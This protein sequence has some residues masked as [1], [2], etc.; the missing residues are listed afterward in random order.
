MTKLL[1]QAAKFVSRGVSVEALRGLSVATAQETVAKLDAGMEDPAYVGAG[2]VNAVGPSRAVM[3]NEFVTPAQIRQVGD[4]HGAAH[5]KMANGVRRMSFGTP[6]ACRN[7]QAET[8]AMM[9]NCGYVP[10]THPMAPGEMQ[11]SKQKGG[12]IHAVNSVANLCND[13]SGPSTM[14]VRHMH[15][16]TSG[17]KHHPRRK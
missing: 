4:K 2:A 11:H 3:A 16:S 7:C 14:T 9:A 13:G 12:M 1:I 15:V 8:H 5:T 17:Y 10:D 6:E